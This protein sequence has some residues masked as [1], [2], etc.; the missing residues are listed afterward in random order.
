MVLNLYRKCGMYCTIFIIM[1]AAITFNGCESLTERELLGMEN[2]LSIDDETQRHIKIDFLNHFWPQSE[3]DYSY[4]DNH[5]RFRY[6]FGTYNGWVVKAHLGFF[7]PVVRIRVDR[8][9]FIFGSAPVRMFA[10]QNDH[11]YE[12]QEAVEKGFLTS[13]NIRTMHERH[14]R[15]ETRQIRR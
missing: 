11:I 12:I 3:I 15:G 7:R 8:Y 13:D 6:Y 4:I 5:F 14:K 2:I 10:W 1:I 9:S